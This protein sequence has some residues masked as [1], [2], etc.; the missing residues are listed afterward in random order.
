MFGTELYQ[1]SERFGLQ[2]PKVSLD[3]DWSNQGGS[4]RGLEQEEQD[5]PSGHFQSKPFFASLTFFSP[6]KG[7]D[8]VQI[9]VSLK[10]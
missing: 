6:C 1:C 7:S 10:E 2:V 5:D 9:A 3:G 4:A 8:N